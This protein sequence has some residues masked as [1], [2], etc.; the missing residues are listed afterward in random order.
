MDAMIAWILSFMTVLAPPGRP[1]FLPE[2]KETQVE[3]TERYDSIARDIQEVVL[4][5]PPVFRGAYAQS[6]TTALILSLMLHESS[7][8]KD[9]DFGVGSKARGDHGNSWC[10]MQINIGTGKTLSWN[11]VRGRFARPG[12]DSAEVELGWT[13]RELV[14]DRKKCIRA[15]LRVVR[16]TLCNNLPQLEWLRA[17]A[18]GS[19]S[20]GSEESQ[21]RM[22]VAIRW[23]NSHKPPM[24]DAELLA[25][26]K[27]AATPLPIQQASSAPQE[28]I[29]LLRP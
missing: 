4:S 9:V 25:E 3:A 21:R 7:F 13:G 17:Y 27:K 6:R 20:Y 12:D 24:T 23:F 15:G 2:A 18:S 28:P 14:E 10:L 8:R 16:G 11:T 5:E 1:Q 22:G 26:V 19:C 29:S